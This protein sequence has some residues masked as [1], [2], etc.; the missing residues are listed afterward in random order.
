MM[1]VWDNEKIKTMKKLES[2]GNYDVQEMDM[3]EMTN[4]NGGGQIAYSIGWL[5]GALVG[6]AQGVIVAVGQAAVPPNNSWQIAPK[7]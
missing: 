2:L 4:A 5:V 1:Q 7:Y 6:A 3:K